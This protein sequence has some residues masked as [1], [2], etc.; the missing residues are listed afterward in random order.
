MNL[1]LNPDGPA[2]LKDS[3]ISIVQVQYIKNGRIGKCQP[4]LEVNESSLLS[5]FSAFNSFSI[6]SQENVAILAMKPSTTPNTKKYS[7]S[8]I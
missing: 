2:N 3:N 5:G 4:T 8:T 6:I 1:Y 7:Q